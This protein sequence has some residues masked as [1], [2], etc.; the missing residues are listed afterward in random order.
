MLLCVKVS[1][2]L[3]LNVNKYD[4]Y[5]LLCVWLPDDLHCCLCR[6]K[7][8]NIFHLPDAFIQSSIHFC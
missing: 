8:I 5:H 3:I 1:A 7:K 4:H 6:K 2:K